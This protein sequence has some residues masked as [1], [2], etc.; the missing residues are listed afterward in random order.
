[1]G[2]RRDSEIAQELA[3]AGATIMAGPGKS[4]TLLIVVGERPFSFGTVRS[5]TY[6]K[7]E[8]LIAEGASLRIV[9]LDEVREMIAR[10][11]KSAE[12]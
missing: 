11:A 7:A 10:T 3:A 12:A 5:A 9:S 8:E 2:T 6:R 4:T 1:M